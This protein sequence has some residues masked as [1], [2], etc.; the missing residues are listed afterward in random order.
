THWL[1]GSSFTLGTFKTTGLFDP[2]DVA[3]TASFRDSY[4]VAQRLVTVAIA[5]LDPAVPRFSTSFRFGIAFRASAGSGPVIK[6]NGV[7][8]TSFAEEDFLYAGLDG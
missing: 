2:N 5:G 7:N 4:V 1:S 6:I 3:D 8:E